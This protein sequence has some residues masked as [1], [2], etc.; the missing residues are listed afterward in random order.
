MPPPLV[1]RSRLSFDGFTLLP[2]E[3]ELRKDGRRIELQ[4]QPLQVLRVL[5][6]RPGQIVSR[7]ELR[8]QVW[9]AGTFVD[10]DHG[11]NNAIKRLRTALGDVPERPRYIETLPRK[12]YRFLGTPR[13]ES[14]ACRSLAVLPFEN[15]LHDPEQAY[16]ADGLTDALITSLAQIGGLRVISRTTATLF[17]DARKPL[18][19]IADELGV[20]VIAIGTVLRSNSRVRV[21]AQLIGM[22]DAATESHLW[23]NSYERDLKDVLALQSELSRT[24]AREIH[25]S[26]T[27]AERDHLSHVPTVNQNDRPVAAT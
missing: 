9:P 22:P 6:A 24:I 2:E 26:L 13:E 17:R 19:K 10:F 8:R 5:L 3:G 12:G 14:A 21:T 11:I 15:L 18:W 27:P 23:A 4:E 1:T 25:V 16:F 7:D 20:D